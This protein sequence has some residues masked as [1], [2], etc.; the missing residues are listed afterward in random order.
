LGLRSILAGCRGCSEIEAL[1]VPDPSSSP[2]YHQQQQQLR[3]LSFVLSFFL[4]LF[5]SF[6]LSFYGEKR[7]W[8][9]SRVGA[10][11]YCFQ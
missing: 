4:S 1:P 10:I 6:S 8:V 2:Q 3:L 9:L 5:L 7:R 11:F